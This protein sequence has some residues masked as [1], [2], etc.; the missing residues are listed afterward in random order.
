MEAQINNM[1]RWIFDKIK[2]YLVA[3]EGCNTYG[4]EQVTDGVKTIVIDSMGYRYELSIKSL[5]RNYE[6][7]N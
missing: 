6:K 7:T 3:K 2:N 4:N 1:N 5:G